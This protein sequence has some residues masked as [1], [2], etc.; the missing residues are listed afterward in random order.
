MTGVLVAVVVFITSVDVA[1]VGLAYRKFVEWVKTI[2]GPVKAK[3]PLPPPPPPKLTMGV[4][5]EVDGEAGDPESDEG[6]L[7]SVEVAACGELV[8]SVVVEVSPTGTIGGAGAI[9]KLCSTDL[10][11]L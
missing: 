10:A 11:A 4:E 9:S 6:L 8:E 2:I 3:P 7:E 5:V 1:C